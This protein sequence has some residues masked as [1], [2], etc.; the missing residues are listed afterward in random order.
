MANEIE[1]KMALFVG[2][3]KALHYKEQH[4]HATKEEILQHISE[5]SD[6]FLDNI[7]NPL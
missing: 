1:M 7:D 5:N 3:D 6:L 2:A 4:P